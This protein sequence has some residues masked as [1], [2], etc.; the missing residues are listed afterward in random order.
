M[1]DNIA[2]APKT[3]MA[4]INPIAIATFFNK[5]YTTI[6][7]H[8]LAAGSIKDRLFDPVSTYFGIVETNE[9]GMLHL[10]CLVWLTGMTNLSNFRQRI[11]GN[12]CYFG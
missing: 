6:I 11:C 7:D 8:L 10:Y 5:T 3:A 2:S 4:T 9:R 12:S 1:S